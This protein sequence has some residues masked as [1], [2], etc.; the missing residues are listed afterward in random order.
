MRGCKEGDT[1][2]LNIEMNSKENQLLY[3]AEKSL[4]PK[5]SQ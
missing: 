3:E 4:R 5:K 2:I 1:Q